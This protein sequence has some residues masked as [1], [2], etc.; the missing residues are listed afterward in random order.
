MKW[1]NINDINVKNNILQIDIKINEAFLTS[2][3]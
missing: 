2:A 1:E 3:I